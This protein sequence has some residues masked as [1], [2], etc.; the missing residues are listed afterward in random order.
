MFIKSV[1][2]FKRFSLSVEFGC[3]FL[4]IYTDSAATIAEVYESS[5]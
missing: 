2:L 5:P 4:A 3:I 1:Q